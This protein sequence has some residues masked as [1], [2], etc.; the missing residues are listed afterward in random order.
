MHS[1]SL[2]G[3]EFY[4]RRLFHPDSGPARARAEWAHYEAV[5]RTDLEILRAGWK[6]L[7]DDRA[8]FAASSGNR[9]RCSPERSH[10]VDRRPWNRFERKQ[11]RGRETRSGKD[12]RARKIRG[13]PQRLHGRTAIRLRLAEIDQDSPR[14]RRTFFYF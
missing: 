3:A 1:P 11:R 2:C 9:S 13:S 7:A 6:S 8:A 10:A 14:R 12:S 5:E 4:Q